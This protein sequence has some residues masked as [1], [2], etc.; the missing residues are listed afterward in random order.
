MNVS[1][2]AKGLAQ[3]DCTVEYDAPDEAQR[4]LDDA[5]SRVRASIKNAGLK[6]VGE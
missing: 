6:E 1:M 4:H 3:W 2:T 5:I